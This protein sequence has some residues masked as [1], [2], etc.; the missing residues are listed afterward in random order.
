MRDPGRNLIEQ[1][2]IQIRHRCG[3]NKLPVILAREQLPTFDHNFIRRDWYIRSVSPLQTL[4]IAG[5]VYS[6]RRFFNREEEHESSIDLNA[7]SEWGREGARWKDVGRNGVEDRHELFLCMRGTRDCPVVLHADEE[8]A[9]I[10]VREGDKCLSDV[11]FDGTHWSRGGGS[12]GPVDCALEF[13]EVT[14]PLRDG[15]A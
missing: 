7:G 6:A 5:L 3:S 12:A 1:F 4:A 13:P 10:S 14:L 15:G 8:F 11:S 2:V 9:A